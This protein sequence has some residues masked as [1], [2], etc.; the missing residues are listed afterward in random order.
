MLLL[1][2]HT[3]KTLI[4]LEDIKGIIKIKRSPL[5]KVHLQ[6]KNPCVKSQSHLRY[7]FCHFWYVYSLF[8]EI[9]E[10]RL[11]HCTLCLWNR[12]F[13]F[14]ILIYPW[15]L[16]VGK[17][18]F[19]VRTTQ[20]AVSNIFLF[21]KAMLTYNWNII[22]CV[23]LKSIIWWALI[24]VYTCGNISTV[25]NMK[26]SI[27]SFPGVSWCLFIISSCYDS[28]LVLGNFSPTSVTASFVFIG[29]LYKWN[30]TI[31]IFFGLIFF[32][33]SNYFYTHSCCRT[34]ISPFLF[35]FRVL[36]HC[37]SIHHLTIKFSCY[38][39]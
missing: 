2:S 10:I 25:K 17:G 21:K 27:S 3:Q 4:S 36:L 16:W 11:I 20:I 24:Y 8:S 37:L 14:I 34:I 1:T 31:C 13:H 6:K 35:Y 33:V 30:H 23:D 39:N 7:I 15:E 38:E 19:T 9:V 18:I 22:K 32:S 5:Y 28:H 29:I 12:K 26:I